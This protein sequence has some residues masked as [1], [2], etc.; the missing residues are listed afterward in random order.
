MHARMIHGMHWRLRCIADAGAAT[1]SRS[2]VDDLDA[3][4]GGGGT[5]AEANDLL[6][7]LGGG[8]RPAAPAK[9][10]SGT[11]RHAPTTP[12]QRCHCQCHCHDAAVH[13]AGGLTL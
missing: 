13:A 7:I 6:D 9:P 10:V 2:A 4:L 11:P 5:A 3:L 1:T 12:H 8:S